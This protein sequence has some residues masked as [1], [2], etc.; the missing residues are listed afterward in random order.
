MDNE[1]YPIEESKDIRFKEPTFIDPLTG[2]FNRYYLYQFLPAELKKAKLSNYPLSLLMI[3]L[4]GFKSIND[5]YGHPCGDEVLKQLGAILKKSIRR[6]DFLIRY[7]GDEFLVL[8][9]TAEAKI[10][11]TV[12][13]SLIDSVDKNVFKGKDGEDLH[14]TLSIGVAIYPDDSEGLDELINLADKALYLSK[15][16]GK[17]RVSH[18]KEVTMEAVSHIVAMD[19]FPCPK[20]ID[21]K[22]EI[23]RLKYIFETIV[24]KSNLLQVVFVAGEP[25]SGKTRLLTELNNYVQ[26]RAAIISCHS[27]MAHIQDPYFLFAKGLAGYIDKIGVDSLGLS[28]VFSRISPLELV[29]LSRIVPPIAELLNRPIAPEADERKARFLLFKGFLD[30]LIELNKNQPVLILFDDIQWIDKASFELLRYLYMQEKNKRIFIVCAYDEDRSSQRTDG[31]GPKALWEDIRFKD[32]FIQLELKDFSF[33]DTSSMIKAIFP[34]IEAGKE[35]YELV[36]EVTKGR[37]SFIEEVLKFLVEDSVISY[38]DNHWQIKKSLSKQDIPYSMEEVIKKRV[39]NLDEE[40]KEMILQAAV[41]GEDFSLGLLKKLSNKDEGFIMELL[42]RAKEMSLVDEL[43]TRG[44]FGFMN[45]NIQRILYNELN[46][47]QRNTLHYKIGQILADEHKDNIDNVAG[48]LAF[49]FNRAPQQDKIN[50]YVGPLLE[51]VN[52]IFNPA[53]AI[54][55]LDKLVQDVVVEKDKVVA[56]ALSEKTFKEAIRLIRAFQGAIKTFYLY[57]PGELR[58]TTIEEAYSLLNVIFGETERLNLGEVE[59][60]LVING[61]RISPKGIDQ[62][63]IEYFLDLMIQN[64]LKTVSFLKGV[65]QDELKRLIQHLTELPEYITEQGGWA[66][67]INKEALTNIRIDEVRFVQ[68]GGLDNVY[69]EKKKFKDAMLIEF[70]LGKIGLAGMDREAFVS[71]MRQDPARFAQT[72]MQTAQKITKEGK[73]LDEAK[74]IVDSIEKINSQILKQESGPNEY[75]TDL[76]KVILQLKPELRNK[77]L[78]YQCLDKDSKQKDVLDNI[79]KAVPDEVIVDMLIEEYK[80]SQGNLLVLK[81]AIEKLLTDTDRRKV[82][83]SKL[84]AELSKLKVSDEE[85]AFAG[86]RIQWKDLSLDKRRDSIIKLPDRYYKSELGKIKTLLGELD[87][88]QNVQ[89]LEDTLL[90]LIDK[91]AGLPLAIRNDLM[92]AITDFIKTPPANNREDALG[93]EDRLDGLLKKLNIEAEPVI[94]AAIL[95]IFKEVIKDSTKR[96][97]SSRN[98]IS[99]MEKPKVKKY[100]LFI[101]QLINILSNRFRWEKE[102]NPQIYKRIENFVRDISSKDFLEILTYIIISGVSREKLALNDIFPIM[103]DTLIETLIHLETKRETTAFDPFQEYITRKG[104]V[105]LLQRLGE[106]AL[107]ILQEKLSRFKDYMAPSLIELIG[108]LKKEEWVDLLMPFTTSDERA[109]RRAVV[110]ALGEIGGERTQEIIRSMLTKEKDK[111]IRILA[112][113][114][115][116]RLKTR[117][118]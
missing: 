35:F 96:L 109:I 90:H 21:R 81:D 57:P 56:T 61:K 29:Q 93:I 102:H 69:E 11:E 37:P 92:A 116:T 98:I 4:D 64:N 23:E 58:N 86:G 107:N 3:D 25:G 115:L 13:R 72:I 51:K 41:I 43:R 104:I 95:E 117:R 49:H 105:N 103:Q 79:I 27:S 16:K 94:F 84:E 83:L 78:H 108:D 39:K 85:V 44:N 66:Q 82:V 114:Q 2:L 20:F 18:A 65:S 7:A 36:F 6:T 60:S 24:L 63:T 14:L 112:K 31:L 100:C 55:Y 50:E 15:Q 5:K 70:L 80:E 91:A 32:N 74:A 48:E 77:V 97:Q 42:N 99:E 45:N 19:S 1:K 47:E 76:V 62:A 89:E 46:N 34:G 71:N 111:K 75:I 106:P 17:N 38:Q 8:L 12:S 87:S 59:R 73:S 26:E 10:A 28:G 53:E 67:I 52:Q 54:E 118:D 22:D 88:R 68:L 30:F 101:Q 113:R 9:P 40:T 33:E 110:T